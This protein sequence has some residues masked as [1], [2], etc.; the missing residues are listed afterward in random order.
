[1]L[2]YSEVAVASF[3]IFLLIQCGNLCVETTTFTCLQ[4]LALAFGLVRGRTRKRR[5]SEKEKE[6][7]RERERNG[8]NLFER[9]NLCL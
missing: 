3:C 4:L 5:A 1:M 6:H 2:S 9:D 7:A 8:E